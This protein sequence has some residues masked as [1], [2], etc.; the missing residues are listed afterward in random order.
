MPCGLN[1]L[2]STESIPVI[3]ISTIIIVVVDII[4]DTAVIIII[5]IHVHIMTT[6]HI[7]QLLECLYPRV[8]VINVPLPGR[9]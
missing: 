3:K 5:I 1:P 9:Y 8:V 7:N 6:Q 2:N 4:V